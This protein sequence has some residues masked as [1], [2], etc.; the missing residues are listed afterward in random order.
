MQ[1]VFLLPRGCDLSVPDATFSGYYLIWNFPEVLSY[2]IPLFWREPAYRWSPYDDLVLPYREDFHLPFP[3]WI[4][5]LLET[6]RNLNIVPVLS[7]LEPV[8]RGRFRRISGQPDRGLVAAEAAGFG[9]AAERLTQCINVFWSP[10]PNL[11]S[12]EWLLCAT[13]KLAQDAKEIALIWDP[14]ESKV[15]AALRY[16]L[17]LSHPEGYLAEKGMLTGVK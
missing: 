11:E 14:A 9:F 4:N 7:G 15:Q 6:H 13:W 2:E 1:R 8:V 5:R 3:V 12:P 10:D 17:Q 16:S